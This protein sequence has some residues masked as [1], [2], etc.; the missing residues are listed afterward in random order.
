MTMGVRPEFLVLVEEGLKPFID[1]EDDLFDGRDLG[2]EVH[3]V[4]SDAL[5]GLVYA[6]VLQDHLLVVTF[7]LV[8]IAGLHEDSHVH[9]HLVLLAGELVLEGPLVVT[10]IGDVGVVLVPGPHA[11][12]VAFSALLIYLNS[13]ARHFYV[14]YHVKTVLLS[15]ASLHSLNL[16]RKPFKNIITSTCP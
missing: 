12:I 4:V 9:E 15:L 10:Q 7:D 1:A 6:A 14:P 8:V 11:V 3:G 16:L 2:D 13:L 5:D